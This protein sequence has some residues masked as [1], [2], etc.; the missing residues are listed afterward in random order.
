MIDREELDLVEERSLPKL[1]GHLKDVSAILWT[2]N[3]AGHAEI[4]AR[5]AGGRER[6]VTTGHQ[7]DWHPKGALP[8]DV[9][10]EAESS[11]VPR[12]EKC[13]RALQLLELEDVCVRAG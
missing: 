13:A 10:H 9:R 8:H 3:V 11:A 12:V 6:L 2:E 4:L 7:P 1:L 5:C